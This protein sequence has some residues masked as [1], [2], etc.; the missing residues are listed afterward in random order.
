MLYPID[1]H[2]LLSATAAALAPDV[3]EAQALVAERMLGLRGTAYT[4]DDADDAASAVALQVSLQVA[5]DP[6]SY[7]AS[8]VTR[9]SRS[10]TY[11][12][13]VVLHPDAV[14]MVAALVTIA[15]VGAAGQWPAI[16]SFR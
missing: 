13:G 1:G 4:G 16:T 3:L 6:E 8:S 14:A 2:P 5:K 9:G 15:T 7:I 11:R 10:L 12:D